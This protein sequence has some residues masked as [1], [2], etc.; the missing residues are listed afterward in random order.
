LVLDTEAASALLSSTAVN[1]KRAEVVT[2]VA[3]AN[4]QRVVPTAVRGA[5]GWDRTDPGAANANRLIRTDD[6]LDRAAGD[7]VA[8]LRGAVRTASVVDAAVAVAAERVGGLGGVVEVLT[9][10]VEDLRVLSAHI[11][12]TVEVVRL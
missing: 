9:S 2:A 3:A 10:D 7:R 12:A 5:S 8:Q 1:P 4:G 6:V 11:H